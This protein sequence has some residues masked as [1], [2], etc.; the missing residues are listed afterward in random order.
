MPTAPPKAC[1]TCGR[2]SCE[3]RTQE[4]RQYQLRAWRRRSKQHM[5]EHP[6]CVDCGRTVYRGPNRKHPRKGHVDHIKPHRG[7][8]TLFWDTANWA[9]RCSLCHAIKTNRERT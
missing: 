5:D 1:T 6:E 4:R 2:T 7:S 8:L 9:T 3:C